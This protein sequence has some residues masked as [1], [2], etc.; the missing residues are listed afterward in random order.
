M[1]ILTWQPLAKIDGVI[2]FFVIL[3][4][5]C[6]AQRTWVQRTQTSYTLRPLRS[7]PRETMVQFG[8]KMMWG[9]RKWDKQVGFPAFCLAP[10][11]NRVQSISI[12]QELMWIIIILDYDCLSVI[13]PNTHWNTCIKFMHSYGQYG[14]QSKAV[15][16]WVSAH[17]PAFS[18]TSPVLL[19]D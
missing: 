11:R 16:L 17:R 7:K 2:M 8:N 9:R 14:L 4:F 6:L 19:T 15:E 13:E 10:A 12:H 1:T 3:A 5:F 18:L